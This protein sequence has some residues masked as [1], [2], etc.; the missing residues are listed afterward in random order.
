MAS[1]I[2][3][4]AERVRTPGCGLVT[5]LN[6]AGAALPTR[7][8]LDAVIGHLRREA[9]RGGYEAAGAASAQLDEV[10]DAAARLVGA[11]ADEIALTGS[12]TQAWTK[13][14]WGYAL[15]GGISSGEVLLVDR[16]A[17]NSHY[18]GLLQVCELTGASIEVMPSTADGSLDVAALGEAL[19]AGPV[20]LVA[21]TQIGT[22]RGLV[23]PVE[24]MGPLCRHAGVP[25]FLDACQSVGQL[26]V[27]VEAIGCDV[28]TGTGR[29]WLR[30]PRGTGFLYVRQEFA[31]R[32][33]PPGISEAGARWLGPDRYELRQ[34]AARF[35]E[36]E[37]PI[38][39]QLGLGVAI[40]H[41]L[42]LGLESIA[43]RVGTLGET[44]RSS[45]A[46]IDG[47]E[48]HDGGVR[49]SG[50]VTFT[51]TAASPELV[52]ETA[53]AARINVSVSTSPWALLDM[54]AP[55]PTAVVRASPHYY[56][57]A[58]ELDRLV[59]VVASCSAG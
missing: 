29:K 22:H 49:R 52:A 38:A 10:L 3:V 58:A 15:G 35:S 19:G 11:R 37:A 8:T 20:A 5:H 7:A 21:V 17:Y 1:A 41:A 33:R 46:E 25:F 53:A 27:D 44:L 30:G 47:V 14:M 45:L 28:L 4:E 18:L 34:G 57:T 2:D 6:N 39:A 16:L 12:D 51:A 54:T 9:E 23:N 50:I 40:Q 56:N 32:L 48:I 26:P 31:D 55:R 24:E 13:A 36:F 59:E 43:A 42:E